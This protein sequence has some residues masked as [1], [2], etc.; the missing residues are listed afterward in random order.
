MLHLDI[1]VVSA[2]VMPCGFGIRDHSIL[3]LTRVALYCMVRS[4]ARLPT[5][6]DLQ[7]PETKYTITLKST[8]TNQ[9][10]YSCGSS[11]CTH[12]GN[13]SASLNTYTIIHICFFI[14]KTM[15][16]ISNSSHSTTPFALSLKWLWCLMFS[17][18]Q[19]KHPSKWLNFLNSLQMTKD[20]N[21]NGFHK[22]VSVEVML[23]D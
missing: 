1:E 23:H 4:A 16:S 13:V 9:H 12:K 10:I 15:L 3:C 7:C 2:C 17:A 21:D 6:P 8:L 11:I 14:S 20:I 19:P 18:H 5:Q 22:I